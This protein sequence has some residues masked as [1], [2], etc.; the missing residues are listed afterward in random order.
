MAQTIEIGAVARSILRKD[1]L[2]PDQAG[3]TARQWAR[4]AGLINERTRIAWQTA[5]WPQVMEVEQRTYRA[6]YN[7]TASYTEDDEVFYEVDGYEWPYWVRTDEA[8]GGAPGT[9]ADWTNY[10]IADGFVPRVDFDQADET[11]IQDVDTAKCIY[12]RNPLLDVTVKPYR[13][14]PTTNGIVAIE[15]SPPDEPW[16]RFRPYAPQFS[17]TDWAEGTAYAAGQRVYYDQ[18]GD[19]ETGQTYLALEANTGK[20]PYDYIEQWKPIDFPVFMRE[21]VEWAVTSDLKLDDEGR[22][23]S[24]ARAKEALERMQEIYIDAQRLSRRAHVSLPI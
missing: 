5:W 13:C 1:G 23:R 15:T 9:S 6:A 8:E 11:L 12:P 7:A 17:L 21:Y 24:E 3:Y 22:Y 16:V 10:L 2:D 14:I 20:I 18:A 19:G 4:L